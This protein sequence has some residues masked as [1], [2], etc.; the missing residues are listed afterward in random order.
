MNWTFLPRRVGPPRRI[1]GLF[2]IALLWPTAAE[3]HLVN[4]GL[5]PLYDGISHLLLSMEDLLPVLAIA[6][7]AGLNGPVAGR[8]SLFALSGA[9]LAGGALGYSTG[10]NVFPDTITCLS[11]LILG[12]LTAADRRLSPHLVLALAIT[13]GLVH[14]WLN[15]VALQTDELEFLSLVGIDATVFVLI[16]L[17]SAVVI[18]MKAV[19]M[20]IVVRVAGSWIAASGLLMLGWSLRGS[21]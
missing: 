14:G 21:I 8:R 6:L 15:G 2:L 9:W 13:L 18:A 19:W 5:G 4:T 3:A 7:L 20:R 12:G 17:I 11:F 10:L 1:G 16:G